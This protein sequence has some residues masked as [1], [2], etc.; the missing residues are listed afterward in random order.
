[1]NFQITL[2]G[3]EKQH[4]K[5]RRLNG[6][7]DTFKTIIENIHKLCINLKEVKVLL[8]L[9]YTKE[10]LDGFVDIIPLIDKEI[11][12]KIEISFQQVWQKKDET[13]IIDLSDF[14]RLFYESGFKEDN[15]RLNFKGY[16]C[17]AD[18]KNQALINY[19]GKVYKCTARDFSKQNPDGILNN[20]GYIEWDNNLF[21]K[22]FGRTTYEN[23]M[24]YECSLIPVC[25][26]PCSQKIVESKTCDDLM[27]F[28]LKDGVIVELNSILKDYHNKV[29]LK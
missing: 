12:N 17:Y 22:R 25:F 2:D 11:R 6:G 29:T 23:T 15:E 16:T 13:G 28:C 20:D 26:G 10:N 1:M 24:C 19:D 9:N 4:N 27:K 21:S 5:I 7:G 18:K 14:R 3:N 8:R